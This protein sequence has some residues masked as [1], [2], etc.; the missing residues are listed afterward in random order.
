ML[1][2][3]KKL[4]LHFTKYIWLSCLNCF[5]H[6]C[7]F[8]TVYFLHFMTT[9]VCPFCCRRYGLYGCPLDPVLFDAVPQASTI[10][11]NSPVVT[12]LA[13]PSLGY[14]GAPVSTVS[15]SPNP[16]SWSSASSSLAC[17]GLLEVQPL[18]FVCCSTSDGARVERGDIQQVASSLG[19]SGVPS[20]VPLLSS[21]MPIPP[22]AALPT[23]SASLAALEEELQMLKVAVVY[24]RLYFTS[25]T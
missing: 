16:E 24:R 17:Q 4:H 18:H 7:G 19:P 21:T 23:V 14:K 25:G 15:S 3:F 9:S 12:S 13:G 10:Q 22:P 6:D 1:N 5:V 8:V 2:S 20:A 11:H